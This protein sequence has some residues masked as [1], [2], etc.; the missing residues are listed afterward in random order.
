M[1][2]EAIA[3]WYCEHLQLEHVLMQRIKSHT[4]KGRVIK[5]SL[6]HGLAGVRHRFLKRTAVCRPRECAFLFI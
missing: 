4:G 1:I 6:D 5:I 3:C 2:I